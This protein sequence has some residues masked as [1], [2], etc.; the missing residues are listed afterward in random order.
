V[1]DE[2]TKRNLSRPR[3]NYDSITMPARASRFNQ[4]TRRE[5]IRLTMYTLCCTTCAT[6]CLSRSAYNFILDFETYLNAS[7]IL[8]NNVCT[9]KEREREREGGGGGRM[10]GRYA[11]IFKGCRLILHFR[12]ALAFFLRLFSKTEITSCSAQLREGVLPSAL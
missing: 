9:C 3:F 12:R 11:R 7:F 6:G 4:A 10:G 8:Q 5:R 1:R 2:K